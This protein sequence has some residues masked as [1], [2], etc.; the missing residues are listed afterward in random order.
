[1][2][3]ALVALAA[4]V[5]AAERVSPDAAAR[6]A[7]PLFMHVG[8][9]LPVRPADRAVHEAARRTTLRVRGRDVVAYEW[10]SG[11]D[12]ILLVHGWRGRAAQFAPIIR[13][14][15][16]EGFRLVA[17]DAPANGESGGR[18]TDIRDWM[19]AIEAMQSHHGRFHTVIGHSFGAM[20]ARTAIT[21]GVAAGALVAV[22]GMADARYLVDTF[23]SRVGIDR[24]SADALADRFARR[25]LPH[26]DDPWARFDGVATPLPERMPLLVVHDRTDREVAVAEAHRLH[27]AHGDRSRLVVTDGHGH[28]RVLGADAALD[29]ITAFVTRGPAGVD[30]LGRTGERTAG[31][32]FALTR[33]SGLVPAGRPRA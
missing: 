22:G 8:S 1:M 28:N 32:R 13:E 14:L 30:A 3:R 25:I 5:R 16:A 24:P 11:P 10:G 20:A 17:F 23:A 2:S 15:R 31:P 7:M 9:P 12:T 6:L 19:A 33:R 29:A 27:E 21:E 18:R 26:L 4:T